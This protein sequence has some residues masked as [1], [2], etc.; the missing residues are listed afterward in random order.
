MNIEI[1]GLRGSAWETL[2]MDKPKTRS[3]LWLWDKESGCV[4]NVRLR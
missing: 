3:L 1:V 2:T 4:W